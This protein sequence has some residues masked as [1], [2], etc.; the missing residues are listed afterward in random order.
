MLSNKINI[1]LAISGLKGLSMLEGALC[2]RN[3]DVKL[4]F[5][6]RYNNSSY[7]E[8]KDLCN[9]KKIRY[10]E[11]KKIEKHTYTIISE[12]I[13]VL[14]IIGWRFKI[15]SQISNFFDKGII[16]FHDSLLPKYRGFSPSFWALING[17]KVTGVSAFFIAEDIDSGDIIFRKKISIT[18]SEDINSLTTKIVNSYKAIFNKI[19]GLLLAGKELP[20][21]VQNPNEASYCIWRTPEDAK[22]NWHDNAEKIS[23][24]IKASK[25]PFFLPYTLF[26]GKK[27]YI[28]EA[29]ISKYR[30]YIGLI[31]GR[32]EN[33]I[34]GD[35]VFILAKDGI[36]KIKKVRLEGE[37]E[38]YAWD[39]I[40]NIT[41]TLE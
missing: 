39:I 36:I 7:K 24:L 35:G 20:R 13:E 40:K 10:I 29:Q 19:I 12:N 11:T 18:S 33:I 25:D 23:N 6:N 34:K 3:I 16:V 37:K 15:P 32:V 31:P 22:I 1:G 41:V 26:Q 27:L 14:F 38:K 8:I 21:S 2:S 4:V 5:L 28:L 17:E 9:Y 30:R